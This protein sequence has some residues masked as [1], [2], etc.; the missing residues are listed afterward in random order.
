[1]VEQIADPPHDGEPH[2]ESAAA[3]PLGIVD[4]IE[5]LKDHLHLVVG[6]SEAGVPDLQADAARVAPCRDEHSAVARVAQRILHQIRQHTLEQERV[7]S[8]DAPRRPEPQGKIVRLGIAAELLV[9][10]SKHIADRK[11][12]R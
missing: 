8:N 11:G 1:M 6:N 10:S 7:A 2:A 5:L 9:Q 3:I 12:L 4:L